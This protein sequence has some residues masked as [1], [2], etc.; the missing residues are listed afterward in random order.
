VISNSVPRRV[1]VLENIELGIGT[2]A[3]GDRLYWGYGHGYSDQDLKEAFDTCVSAGVKFFDTAEGYGQGR[4]ETLLGEFIRQST[5]PVIVATKFMPYPWRLSRSALL[6]SLQKSV[7]RL[8]LQQVDLYQIHFPLPPININTWM[9]AM[10]EAVHSG[11]TKAVGVSNYDRSQMQQAYDALV[12]EGIQL[13][14][15]Q[16]EYN[17]LNRKVEKNGL[18][19]QCQEMGAALI[20]YSPIAMGVLSGKY[21]PENPPKGLRGNRFNSRYLAQIQP[22]VKILMKI[23]NDHAG[24]TAAQVAINWVL[25]K[26]AIPIPG[27]KNILQAEQNVGV[28]N[29][30]LSEEEVALLDETSDRVM[31]ATIPIR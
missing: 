27:V 12:R 7:K 11:L 21:T 2:W 14:S 23:G 5:E 15:N 4:S 16:V 9:T 19:K 3:W 30:R 1:A 29:W 6:R 20:A 24:K 17:L 31:Q 22:L 18:L 25:C 26:G 10:I 28:L 8:G 13:A